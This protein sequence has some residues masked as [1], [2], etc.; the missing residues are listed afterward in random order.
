M[1]KEGT[2]RKKVQSGF[3]LSRFLPQ[4]TRVK[5][6]EPGEF[7]LLRFHFLFRILSRCRKE[8]EGKEEKPFNL[9][10]FFFLSFCHFLSFFPF[11][12]SE[13]SHLR[14][15]TRPLALEDRKCTPLLFPAVLSLGPKEQ[16]VFANFFPCFDLIRWHRF[17][18]QQLHFFSLSNIVHYYYCLI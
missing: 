6:I 10:A 7:D 2:K 15:I 9:A 4:A 17:V 12:F 1:A 5:R 18:R 13:K 11:H 8:E 14:P 3:D 16:L